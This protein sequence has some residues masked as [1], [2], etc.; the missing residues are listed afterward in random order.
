M[1]SRY[2]SLTLYA[3]MSHRPGSAGMAQTWIR[4]GDTRNVYFQRRIR[5]ANGTRSLQEG[6]MLQLPVW[7]AEDHIIEES[8]SQRFWLYLAAMIGDEQIMMVGSYSFHTSYQVVYTSY[9]LYRADGDD[10]GW[11]RENAM[12]GIG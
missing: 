12:A 10:H 11:H 5:M 8:S 2:E 4:D 7:G 6:K 3:A 9:L 1:G